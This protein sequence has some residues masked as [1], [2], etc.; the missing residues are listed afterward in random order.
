MFAEWSLRFAVFKDAVTRSGASGPENVPTPPRLCTKVAAQDR[1]GPLGG[2]YNAPSPAGG[3]GAG[4]RE[5]G[6]LS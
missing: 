2:A 1:P 5:D 6:P 4:E 3:G